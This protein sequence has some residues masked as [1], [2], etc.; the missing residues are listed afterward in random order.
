V[1]VTNGARG[2][3]GV[4]SGEMVS[5]NCPVVE[6]VDPTGAGDAFCAGLIAAR[7]HDMDGRSALELAA[8]TA[9]FQVGMPG[10]VAEPDRF[11]AVRD[12]LCGDASRS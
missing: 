1:I 7:L 8:R 5:A 11:A 12:E 9:A 2:C 3:G 6:A 4:I 10:G